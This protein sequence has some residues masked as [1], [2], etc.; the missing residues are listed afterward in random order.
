MDFKLHFEDHFSLSYL[1]RHIAE[2]VE[3]FAKEL[4]LG[5]KPDMIKGDDKKML[6][7]AA[8]EHDW[9]SFFILERF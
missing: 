3:A 1:D 9:F 5:I 2:H 4:R 6:T 7:N 8:S